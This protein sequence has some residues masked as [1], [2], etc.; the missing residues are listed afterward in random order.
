MQRV[1]SR[2]PRTLSPASSGEWLAAARHSPWPV[3]IGAGLIALGQW[4]WYQDP[5]VFWDGAL[6][7]GPGM[8]LVLAGAR[9]ARLGAHHVGKAPDVA[10][11]AGVSSRWLL[12]ALG[13]AL[14]VY[15]GWSGVEKQHPVWAYLALWLGGVGLTIAGLVPWA[16]ASAW[17]ARLRASVRDERRTWL[18]LGA[19]LAGALAVRLAFLE[20][21]PA[22]QAGDEAQFA[23]EAVSIARDTDWH[24]SPFQMGIWHHPRTV[25]TLMA[26]SIELLG[27]TKAAARLPWALFG[28][29]SVPAVYVLGRTLAGQGVGWA[30]ALFMLTFPAHVQFSRTGMDMTGD[31]F[32]AALTLALLARA[33]RTGDRM[34]AALGGAAGGLTQYFYFAGR[35]V[36]LLMAGYVAL[37]LIRSPR[38]M[39]QRLGALAVGAVVFGVT[40]FP[41]FY[42]AARDTSRPLNPRLNA[43]GVWQTAAAEQAQADGR[44]GEFWANQLHRGLMAYVQTSDESDVYGRYGA[45]LGWFA[46]VPFLVGVAAAVRCWRSPDALILPIW[47]LAVATF[48]G[49]LLID[50]PHYPR[51]IIATPALAVLVGIGV[52]TLG[53]ALA[54]A[55][56]SGAALRPR[57]VGQLRRGLPVLLAIGLMLA[58]FIVYVF[59]YLPRPLLYGE[60]TTQLNDI[61][62]ILDTFDGR[63][64]VHTLSA[65]DLSMSGTDILR[66][67]TPENAGVEYTG[68][69]DDPPDGL[70]PGPHAFVIAPARL[71]EFHRLAVWLPGGQLRQYINPRTGRPLVYVYLVEVD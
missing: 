36:P 12:A 27:Q 64:E 23:T 7:A 13:I 68:S 53:Q 60:R 61:A 9:P 6:L 42:G 48:G 62:A 8:L 22:I 43:V 39:R 4:V 18:L 65:L 1:F 49:V 34:D 11:R 67:L 3:L 30:A 29:L 10:L 25:H 33:L 16:S 54:R 21:V 15:A 44:L 52:V 19:L 41:Y 20:T 35:I 71:Q 47:A 31:P 51:Y 2:L 32:F 38:R 17:A 26:V 50:P 14:S 46:G 24:F 55:L 45:L 56:A 5:T 40:V 66:Y 70:A 58:N 37:A 63:Y 69:G 57:A 28:A 59:D